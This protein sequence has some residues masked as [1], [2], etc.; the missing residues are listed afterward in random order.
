MPCFFKEELFKRGIVFTKEQEYKQ[1]NEKLHA[2]A[3]LSDIYNI[4]C[5]VE[6]EWR[7][8][9]KGD[10][11]KCS[12]VNVEMAFPSATNLEKKKS[13]AVIPENNGAPLYMNIPYGGSSSQG[14]FVSAL[15]LTYNSNPNDQSLRQNG[16]PLCTNVHYDGS[17]SQGNVVSALNLLSNSNPNDQSLCQSTMAAVGYCPPLYFDP[18]TE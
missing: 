3:N 11:H 7:E 12:K 17:S 4:F 6:S 14:N 2:T 18:R 13:V 9:K 8:K 1:L 16:A 10:N 15:N 5:G